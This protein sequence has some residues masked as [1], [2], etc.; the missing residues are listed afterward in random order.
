[1]AAP[2]ALRYSTASP[3]RP[4]NA[5]SSDPA[6]LASSRTGALAS[7]RPRP[8]TI[9]CSA[10]SSISLIRWLDTNTVRPSRAMR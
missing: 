7:S 1:M 2:S 3:V 8:I 6:R 4:K 9:S 5:S 10:I